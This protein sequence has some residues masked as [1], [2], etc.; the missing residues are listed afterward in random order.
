M[1]DVLLL[2]P[3]ARPAVLIEVAD[4]TP[5]L[6]LGGVQGPQGEP[7]IGIPAGGAA[8]QVLAKASSGDYDTTWTIV[9]GEGGVAVEGSP[10]PQGQTGPQGVAGPSGPKGDKGDTGATGPV[11]ATGT[12]GS[13]GAV[14]PTGATGPA[15]STGPTG[16]QGPVGATGP[17]GDTGTTGA[18]GATGPAGSTGPVGSP[19]PTGATGAQGPVGATGPQGATGEAGATGPQGAVGATGATGGV[20]PTGNTG[21]AGEQGPQGLPGQIGATGPVGPPGLTGATGPT[22]TAGS[23]G[24]TGPQGATGSTGPTGPQGLN[25]SSILGPSPG[26]LTRPSGGTTPF[27]Y[28]GYPAYIN[29]NAIA[30]SANVI[31]LSPWV[32]YR[33]G[34]I[35]GVSIAI[36][37]TGTGSAVAGLYTS[38]NSTS[39]PTTPI[40]NSSGAAV[41]GFRYIWAPISISVTQGQLY[42]WAYWSNVAHT[43]YGPPSTSYVSGIVPQFAVTPNVNSYPG[44]WDYTATYFGVLP[45][46]SFPTT[47]TITPWAVSTQPPIGIWLEWGS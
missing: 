10:G 9:T 13:T 2:D 42:Y 20:G 4:Q 7:G 23:I 37:T 33:S 40:W 36:A 29:N 34:T 19:G 11:G 5:R 43:L 8:G 21:P 25:G 28:A 24:A 47:S 16:P 32:A 38:S 1:P 31:H 15:G 14:G 12:P 17:T 45:T 30:V 35:I 39:T 22:G 26:V 46:L 44:R 41:T 6:L 27:W 3:H 18:T